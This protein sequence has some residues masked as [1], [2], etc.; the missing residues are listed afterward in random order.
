M[1]PLLNHRRSS[2]PPWRSS[3]SPRRS[4]HRSTNR[5]SE[6]SSAQAARSLQ[7]VAPQVRSPRWRPAPISPA[8]HRPLIQR[9][10]LI[11]WGGL[12]LGGFLLLLHLFRLQVLDGAALRDRAAGQQIINVGELSHRRSVTD[13]NGVVL[14]IDQ[15]VYVLYAHPILFKQDIRDIAETIAP[16]LERSPSDLIL[17]MS[18][19]ESG[20]PLQRDIPE[21]LAERLQNTIR[22]NGLDGLQLD[23]YRQRLYP[24]QD[25]F[26]TV[27]G[28]VNFDQDPQAGLEY[29]Q[30]DLLARSLQPS[31]LRRTGEGLM[32]P[33][34]APNQLIQPDQLALQLTLDSQLQ[35]IAQQQLR[36]QITQFDAKR[37]ALLVMD[38]QDGS[39]LALATEPTYDPNRYFETAPENMRNWAISDVYEP[40]S[41]FK[42]INV[43]IAL[44][45]DAI[46]PDDVIYDEGRI[47]LDI[48]TIENA[49]YEAVG[50]RGAINITDIIKYSSNI[51]MVRI[52]QQ[53]KTED[54]YEWLETLLSQ[55]TGIDLDVEANTLLKPKD[56]FSAV[57][58]ATAAFG[59]GFSLTP[60]R[61]LQLHASLANGGRLVTPHV[62]RGLVDPQG[63]LTWRQ[64]LSDRRVFS[65]ETARQVLNM[66]EAV[67]TSGTGTSASIPGYRT[68]GKTGTAQK[69]SERG[70]YDEFAK[71]T[72]YVGFL[73]ADAPRYVVLAIID[74]PK[75]ENTFGSTVAAPAVK[76]VMEAL[77]A[78]EGIPPS[79]SRSSLP[80]AP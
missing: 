15:T 9:R 20:I 24:Q 5:Y 38:V 56:E 45:A 42:P 66:M 13:R 41:T 26:G 16:I 28:Y 1:N 79:R 18:S 6:A 21:N 47:N 40:G 58:V 62:V 60:I 2:R 44:E 80:N 51:G 7:S 59:Q 14:A 61:L 34:G 25:L 29:S 49:D 3:Q 17:A 76:A 23:P 27:V 64:S 74:E 30:D 67:V 32:L 78:S 73:P 71:I 11:V 22:M 31:E 33:D 50:G 65:P 53:M 75:G 63:T 36:Q 72:S 54:Y 46:Q 55:P 52:M 12:I 70:G 69:A 39:M 37:G 10:L 43:A 19:G 68:A 57:E 8:Q 48:W 35:R 77:I 4:R